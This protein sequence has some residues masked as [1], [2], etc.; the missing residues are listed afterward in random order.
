MISLGVVRAKLGTANQGQG[1]LGSEARLREAAVKEQDLGR[2]G[3]KI[4]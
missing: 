4:P 3:L 1:M 2:Q